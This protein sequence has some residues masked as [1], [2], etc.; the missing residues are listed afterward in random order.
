MAEKHTQATEL[1]ELTAISGELPAAAV[2]RLGGGGQY[3]EKLV[4]H[5]K[6]SGVIKLHCKDRLRGYR[7]TPKTKQTL[8]ESNPDRF[9]FYL[10]GASETNIPQSNIKRRLRLH[11][12]ADVV[13]TMY[14][15]GIKVFRDEKPDVFN[16]DKTDVIEIIQPSFYGSREFKEIGH[17]MVKAQN[18]RAVGIL[19]TPKEIYIVYNTEN[20]TMKWDYKS[21]ISVKTIMAQYLCHTRMRNQYPTFQV[22]GLLFGDSIEMM[23][24]T[25]TGKDKPKRGYFFLDSAFDKFIYLTNDSYGEVQLRLL[26]D[27]AKR[28]ELDGIIRD[29]LQPP[30]EMMRIDNDAVDGS[31][32]PV[33]FAYLPDMPRLARFASALKLQN[34]SGTVI[35]FDFQQ[36]ILAGYCGERAEFEVINFEKCREMLVL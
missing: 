28:A 18:A 16:A 11:R 13:V 7:L 26:C 1:T 32:N 10:T 23:Y 12:I 17:E 6:K 25:L 9:K 34:R 14:N 29:T 15:A 21:E 30:D 27:T 3:K 4:S 5:L 31:G 33:L 36:E 8:L 19:L 2:Y 22:T 20:Q 24:E 35:C